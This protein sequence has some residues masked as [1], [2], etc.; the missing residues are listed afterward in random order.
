V[1]SRALAGAFAAAVISLA[2][3][4]A[5]SL[6]RS[7][8]AA[9]LAVGT[10]AATAGWPWAGLLI[11]FFISSSALSRLGRARK[12]AWSGRVIE[13]SG[14]RDAWQVMAN[15]GV[16]ALAAIGAI[17][18]PNAL[19]PVIGAGALAASTADTWST[20][21]GTL[22]GGT[23]R[24]VVSGRPVGVGISGGITLIGT[25]AAVGGAAL[26][27]AFALWWQG[28]TRVGV[29]VLAGGVAG[30]MADSI[31][32]ATVQERRWCRTCEESTERVIHACGTRTDVVGGVR[33]CRNDAVNA[34]ASIVG[35][36][37]AALARVE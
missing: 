27:A 8:V 11:A 9:A 29:S 30:A 21:I 3:Y 25:L 24:S 6:A 33:G 20:E 26:V 7:G 16:F 22:A 28:S 10:I 36:G 31:F 15:G 2:A 32:G 18:W 23:P 5:G 17:V 34:M 14:A 19:W 12:E 4:R 1:L 35:A 37:V 13:K